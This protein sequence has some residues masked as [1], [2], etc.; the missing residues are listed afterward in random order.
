MTSATLSKEYDGTA[1]TNGD[2]AL[3]VESGWADGEGA[4]YS[5][6]GSQTLVGNSPNAF[7]YTLNSNTLAGNYEIQKSEGTLTVSNR[8]AAYEVTVTASS[9]TAIYDG[10]EKSVSGFVG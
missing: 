10:T 2:T 4:S 6:T 5:F 9:L 8:N 7:D 3:A 1:L